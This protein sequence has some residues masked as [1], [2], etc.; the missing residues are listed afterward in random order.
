MKTTDTVK[1]PV[2]VFYRP[3]ARLMVVSFADHGRYIYHDV[4]TRVYDALRAAPAR[5]RAQFVQ[6]DG[7]NYSV[8]RGISPR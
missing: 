8:I 5:V 2:S 6:A 3:A 1:K 7:H 4:S